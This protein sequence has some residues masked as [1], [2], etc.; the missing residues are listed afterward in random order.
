MS[1]SAPKP[2][3]RLPDIELRHRSLGQ[4]KGKASFC[5]QK[6]ATNFFNLG[7]A[8][9]NATGPGEQRFFAPLFVKK[10]PLPLS[11]KPAQA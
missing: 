8:G 9:S 7:R 11:E 2:R 10:R 6:E 4:A 3:A 5:E 1:P